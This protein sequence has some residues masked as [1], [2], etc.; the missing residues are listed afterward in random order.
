MILY[1]YPKI[2]RI[3]LFEI[4][5]P[6]NQIKIQVGEED[7]NEAWS[8]KAEDWT[9]SSSPASLSQLVFVFPSPARDIS[10]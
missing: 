5:G 3:S 6:E 1:P 2:F 4:Y 10:S 9:L 8:L 7:E